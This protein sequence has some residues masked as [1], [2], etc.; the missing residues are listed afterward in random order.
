MYYS[1]FFQGANL[2]FFNFVA[3]K[4][5]AKYYIPIALLLVIC[6]CADI[7]FGSVEI[8]IREV[9][10]AL[11]NLAP[12]AGETASDSAAGIASGSA[13]AAAG[14][15]RDIVLDFRL[16]KAITAL[17]A[18]IGLSLCGLQMQTLFRNPLADPYIL[19]VSA[20]SGLGVAVFVMGSS[21][22]GFETS[23]PFF[24]T[25]GIAGA[26]MVGAFGLMTLIISLSHRLKNN[27]SL[28]IFGVMIG[29]V[30]SA[31]IN[32]LQYFTS[33]SSLKMYVVW[34]MGSFAGVS[35]RQLWGLAVMVVAGVALSVYN[36]KDLN[37]LLL[38]EQ[39]ASALGLN[40][41][42][43]K[44]RILVATTLLAGGVTAFCGPIGFIGIAVPHITR[45][46]FRDANHKVLLPAT[47][48]VGGC[49]MLIADI[50]TQVPAGGG[51]IPV[52]TVAALLGIPVILVIILK[53]KV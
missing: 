48:L 43:I 52:N 27:L 36:I 3:M 6:F 45:F 33:A 37:A 53:N 50:L 11:L 49:M 26:A 12:Q 51:V 20:A 25:Y 24:Q 42:G 31:V 34:T 29:S 19:G 38:G 41:R 21:L 44:I 16:P 2:I 1:L 39:Y 17:L 8:S 10:Q 13:G 30:A 22:I 46:I 5:Y 35:D 14:Y 7:I 28:L 9:F 23:H 47:A 4:K 40:V 15:I 32:L 18:G